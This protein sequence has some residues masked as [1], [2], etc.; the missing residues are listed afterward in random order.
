[1]RQL[2][3]AATLA[4]VAVMAVG[5]SNDPERTV[6]VPAADASPEELVRAYVDAL[7]SGDLDTA[8][9]LE[10]EGAGLAD[11]WADVDSVTDL[12]VGDPF[13]ETHRSSPRRQVVN[14]P[15]E[16]TVAG[17]DASLEDGRMVWGYI[18]ERRG[19]GEPWRIIGHGTG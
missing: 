2:A 1:M 6:P 11:D 17:G 15:V 7:D 13:R 18:L 10:A 12:K 9:A 14:V 5:C 16:F 4:A 3:R 19:A 8:R